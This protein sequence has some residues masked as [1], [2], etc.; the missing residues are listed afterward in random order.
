M[1]G[2]LLSCAILVACSSSS[3]DGSGNPDGGGTTI[4]PC[5]DCTPTGES[6]FALPSPAGATLWTTTTMDKVLREATPPTKQG[7]SLAISAA[8]NEFEPFQ[9]VLRADTD[10]NATIAIAPIPGISRVEIHR[11]GYVK[12]SEPSDPGSIKSPWMPDPL[13]PTTFGASEALKAGENQ[14]FWITVYVPP[15]A[16]AGDLTT[17]LSITIGGNKQDI[18]LKLHVFDFALPPQ[19]GFDGNWNGSFEALGG[20]ES[21]TKVQALKT[22]FY[23]HR[24]TPSSVA[25]PA[26]LNYDGGIEFDCAAGKLVDKT[27]DYEMSSLGP[28]YVDGKGW[29]GVGFPSFQAMDFV[30]NSTPR[31]QKFCGVDRG[32]TNYGTPEYDAAWSK[33]LAAV[34]AYAVAHGWDKKAYYYVQNEPQ[35][36]A[37]YDLA[38]YL[39]DLT[40]RA[41]PHLRIAISEE[42][43]PEI[44]ENPKAMGASYD[45]WWANLSEFKP[46]YAKV[47]QAKGESVWWYFLYGDLPPHFNPITIDHPG[48]ESRIPFWAAWKYRVRGFAYYSLTGWGS[49]PYSNPK[50]QGTNQNGDGYLF[51]PPKGGALVSSIRWE[52][53]REGAEDFEYLLLASGGAMPATPDSAGG[54]DASV[55]SAVSSTTTY[56]RDA[57]ALKHLRDELGAMLEK[58]RD[59][60]PTLS[61]TSTTAHPRAP[62]FINFQDP[63]GEPKAMPLTVDG[64]DWL[65][66]GWS[67]YD[68][69]LGY[70]WSGPNIGHADIML[71]Q[72]LADAPVNELQKSVI[73]DDYGRTDTFAWD[74]ANGKYTVTVSIG[75]SG[76]TYS[77]QRI[78]VEGQ[79]L[80]DNAETNPT[81]PYLV[82]SVDV[83]VTDGNVTLEAGQK[84][85]YTMLNWMSIVPR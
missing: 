82:K 72:Y 47:R 45:L 50:P 24:L 59:G 13:E 4:P 30:D 53:L 57:S 2:A 12:I 37:D 3:D 43:K 58:K 18:P 81:T 61:S 62:Y 15:D 67:A 74:I 1:R 6:T 22:W 84:D 25:W 48:I 55:A 11:V 49:D 77:K 44:A 69:K 9:I 60:C 5:T 21:L 19:I 16:K 75:W 79:L 46:D 52:L 34:D 70:G 7:D 73:Y 65:K 35:N 8:K 41:A 68:A 85:E 56:T 14:P 39:A 23:E 33:L 83:D 64:H 66:I 54:C 51:Y 20:G 38:A 78:V 80:F 29:N 40:K 17:T 31:P 32:P 28:K 63:A 42:P 76:K 27:G 36:A 71:Y 26:G 10:A